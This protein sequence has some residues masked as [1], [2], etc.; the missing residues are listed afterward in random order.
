[1]TGSHQMNLQGIPAL[2]R[3]LCWSCQLISQDIL[4]GTGKLQRD[5]VSFHLELVSAPEGAARL[6]YLGKPGWVGQGGEGNEWE[7]NRQMG[8]WVTISFLWIRPSWPRASQ[9]TNATQLLL[10]GHRSPLPLTLCIS[11]RSSVA[12]HMRRSAPGCAGPRA[13]VQSCISF[14]RQSAPGA[15]RC[16]SRR[17]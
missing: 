4:P 10:A 15:H 2:R 17:D 6:W 13:G 9:V 7:D 8:R 12:G 11:K 1:M 16:S 14:P 3:A 5:P